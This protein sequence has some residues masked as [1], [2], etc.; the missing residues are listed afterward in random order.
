ML[1]ITAVCGGGGAPN[2]SEATL[3]GSG[4]S[5]SNPSALFVSV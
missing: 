2:G 3:R 4:T 1:K 5:I